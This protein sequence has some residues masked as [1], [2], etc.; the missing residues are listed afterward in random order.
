MTGPRLGR[1][2]LYRKVLRS[3]DYWFWELYGGNE[4][5]VATSNPYSSRQHALYGIDR[6][7][8]LAQTDIIIE[9]QIGDSR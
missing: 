4:I 6:H 8:I 3:K 1:Y 9:V 7:K 2:K 5:R